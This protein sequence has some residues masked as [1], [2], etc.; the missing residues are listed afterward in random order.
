MFYKYDNNEL[1]YG[2]RVDSGAYALYPWEL[3]TYTL[4]IE[5]WYW[6]DTIEEAKAFFNIEE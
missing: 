1:Y 5:G 3:D 6:F 2:P 4:P